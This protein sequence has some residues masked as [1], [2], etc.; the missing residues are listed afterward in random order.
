MK[1]KIW[2][3]FLVLALAVSPVLL[4]GCAPAATE[5]KPTITFIQG[6]WSS[7]L[8]CTEIVE[9]IVSEQLA[10]PTDRVAVAISLGWPA[11]EKG[12][13][14][15]AT[16]IWLPLRQPEIQ[17]Y[18]DKG[19][20]E[21][22]GEIFPGGSGWI[23]PRFVVEGDPARGIEPMAPDLKSFLDLKD[24][25]KGGKGYWKL[26]ENPEKPGLGELVGGSPGW[27]DDPSDRSMIRAYEL[28]LW[29]SNQTEAIMCTRMI[30]ADKKGD[31]LLMYIWWP[32]WIL[33]AVDVIVLEEPDPYYE[34]CFEDEEKDYK[35]GHA[36]FSVNKVVVPELKDKAPDVYRLMQNLVISE[37]E[38]NSLMLRVDKYE[39]DIP[40]VAADWISQNQD[41]IDQ[42][43]GK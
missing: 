33:G 41:V 16:E 32:H 37:D 7:Q 20:L 8:I 3:A 31:P 26:F 9:Q 27:V 11:M 22:A 6:D 13:A 21:L 43:L 1:N 12:E 35:C 5:E 18:L 25:D 2:L 14:D 36:W 42:W 23:I 24:V 19:C 4:H 15:I 40:A 30:A 38:I 34:G 39:E 17:P 28:P 10:Y 29:R